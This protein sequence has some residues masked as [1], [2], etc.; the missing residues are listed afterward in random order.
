MNTP[1]KW[2]PCSEQGHR[3]TTCS[4]SVISQD[5]LLGRRVF[6]SSCLF[7]GGSSSAF[8]FSLHLRWVPHEQLLAACPAPPSAST[9]SCPRPCGM[10]AGGARAERACETRC[11]FGKQ[12]TYEPSS[13]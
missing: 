10:P 8:D 11:S 3:G 7:Q 1:P 5:T 13:F 9:P 2:L 12:V 4:P 6:T